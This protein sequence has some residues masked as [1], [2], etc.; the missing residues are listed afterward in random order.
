VA[1]SAVI[2]WIHPGWVR[3]EFTASLLAVARK[4]GG[5]QA[6]GFLAVVSGPNVSEARNLL[7]QR[8]LDEYDAPWLLMADTDMV[9][10]A[11]ALDRLIQAADP[12]DRPVVGALCY[13]QDAGGEV[14]P[15]MYRLV[16]DSAGPRGFARYRDYPEGACLRVDGTGA[17]F[18]LAHR[19]AL[20][21][22]RAST[23]DI[24]APWFRES[25][26]DVCLLGEDLTFCLRATAAGIPVHVCT[27]VQVGHMK[28]RMLGKVT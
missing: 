9:F 21:K 20:E 15:L 2:G 13:S 7:V 6:A 14:H 23:G 26:L 10:S 16:A 17:A 4:P 3:A 1:D 27:Q 12:A 8:F 11:D 22:I 18:L 24:A 19:S 25:T 28:T 5:V